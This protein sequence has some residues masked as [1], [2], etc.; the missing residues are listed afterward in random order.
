MGK[1]KKRNPSNLHPFI[2]DKQGS[3]HNWHSWNRNKN[4]E[5]ALK[6]DMKQRQIKG[7]NN[8]R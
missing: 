4:E 5:L 6:E 2:P 7:N 1:G 8:K 3:G